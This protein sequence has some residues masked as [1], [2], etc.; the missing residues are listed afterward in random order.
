MSRLAVV[1]LD[2]AERS[3]LHELVDAGE[4]PILAGLVERG[5]EWPLR[6]DVPYRAEYANTELLTGRAPATTRYWSTVVFDPDSYACATVGSARREPFYAV[7]DLEVVAFDVPHAVLVDGQPGAQVVGWGGHDARFQHPRASLPSGLM[8]EIDARFGP[9][10]STAVEFT[11]SWHQERYL[12]ALADSLVA[13]ARRRA[14]ISIRLLRRHPGWDLV[15]TGL[16]E[17]H[18]AGHNMA[19][20]V[21]PSHQ[22][23]SHPS[24]ALARRCFVEVY[25]AVD[26]AVGRI[27]AAL[28]DDA[29]LG[30]L[31]PK[32][33]R[34]N[35]DDV[36]SAVLVPELLHRLA[37]GRPFLHEP[38]HRAWRRRGHPPVAPDPA[39]RSGDRLDRLGA[40]GPLAPLKRWYHLAAPPAAMR[41][42]R[43]LRNVAPVRAVLDRD[44]DR[45]APR[46]VAPVPP[47][48]E[49]VVLAGTVDWHP[50]MRYHHRWPSM[51]WFALP[52]FSD[53]HIRVNLAGRESGGIVAAAD[54]HPACDR[55]EA[56][57]RDAID[58]RTGEPVVDDV[59]RL[60]ADDPFAPDGP[61]ADL[62]VTV[63]APVDALEHPRAGTVGPF[64]FPRSGSH[65]T[66]G[67]LLLAG[68]GIE[69]GARE[70]QPAIRLAATM[71]QLLGVRPPFPLDGPPLTGLDLPLPGVSA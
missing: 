2:S 44:R 13:S 54:Y 66:A 32:G 6:G 29:V 12:R 11:G 55:L 33:M 34:P 52:S 40:G 15:V 39:R 62:V 7:P 17:L 26:D 9:D 46:R 22:L 56:E 64:A 38:T 37:G 41:A 47:D 30:A 68:P 16:S 27:E 50:A 61:G 19:H 24:A 8:A 49:P 36:A 60:R 31:T 4:L 21:D 45:R 1:V 53:A 69:P 58:P 20:G 43:Q 23:G 48:G 67:F 51:P 5:A 28:P 57:L 18:S 14:D 25:R 65:T 63:R 3:F 42:T 35:R 71:L 59:I 10:P 70:E